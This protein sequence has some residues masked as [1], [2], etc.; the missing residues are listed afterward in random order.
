MK[1][2]EFYDLVIEVAIIRP[3][4]IQG[5]LM[6]PFLARREGLEA[7]TYLDSRLI[8]VLERTLGVPLF[9]EQ[10]LKIAMVMAD[11]SGN[12]AEELRRALSYHRSQ[13]RMQRVEKKLRDAL[14]A[15]DVND[16]VA[17]KILAAITSFALYGFPESHAISFALIAY[18][19]SW[20][21]VHRPAEF[22]VGLL[23]NQPMGFYAPAT[24]IKDAQRH[25]IKVQPASIVDSQWLCTVESDESIRLGFCLMCGVNQTHVEQMLSTRRERPFQSMPDFRERTTFE[26]D[27]LRILAKAGALN[28]LIGHR[29]DALWAVEG[30]FYQGELF[31]DTPV[32]LASP[33]VPM[34]PVERLAADFSAMRLTTGPHP[35]GYLRKSL[36]DDIWRSA[37][38]PFGKNGTRIRIAGLAICRQRPGTA[39]G[40]VFISLEDETGISN[41]IVTPKIFEK[42]PLVITQETFLLIEGVLQ[43][44]SGVIHIRAEK[45]ERLPALEL[46]TADSHDFC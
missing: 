7:I 43:L 21:K 11:F 22:Y 13:E 19:S 41:S 20:L 25:R 26:R 38:L 8:P 40:F 32:E 30:E 44:Q 10:M 33:L 46:E 36:P 6:H 29:R 1:P 17:E 4:P 2:K 31:S 24:L 9:Q 28:P 18:A 42:N 5:H 14:R 35:M 27:E 3:G 23:N 39:K 12:E 37:D 15:K 45:I 34:Q 16:E